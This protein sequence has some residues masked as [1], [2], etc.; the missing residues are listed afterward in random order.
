MRET[1]TISLKGTRVA[2]QEFE[3]FQNGGATS[4][5]TIL[6]EEGDVYSLTFVASV[7]TSGYEREIRIYQSP[8]LT[9]GLAKIEWIKMEKGDSITNWLPAPEDDSDPVRIYA[10]STY[11]T[12]NSAPFRVTQ[13]GNLHAEQ[14]VFSGL[15][16]GRFSLGD[17]EITDDN[18]EIDGLA[19][20][21]F[22][23]DDDVTTTYPIL[24]SATSG[25]HFNI[26]FSI[27][28]EDDPRFLVRS[29]EVLI[30]THEL[31]ISQNEDSGIVSKDVVFPNSDTDKL[32]KFNDHSHNIDV[33]NNELLFNA[34]SNPTNYHFKFQHNNTG[35]FIK[36]LIDGS[37]EIN[38]YI[39][40]GKLKI[41]KKT[42]VGNSGIDFTFE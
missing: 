17:I 10:G 26:P 35:G 38:N 24:I 18:G 7:A 36:A 1:Y 8:E 30:K 25:S 9:T 40:Y 31:R 37:L 23:H 6:L 3:L 5:G 21:R 29:N 2:G 12:R 27:G 41:V 33:I 16:T 34:N 20:I 22:I 15:F 11:E 39:G 4:K 13:S 42:D 19:E 32:I 28:A 14:G